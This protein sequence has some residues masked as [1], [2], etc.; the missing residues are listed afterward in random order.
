MATVTVNVTGGIPTP[1][2]VQLQAG[3]ILVFNNNDTNPYLIQLWTENQVCIEIGILLAASQSNV[4]LMTDPNNP[5][6]TIYYNLLVPGQRTNPA[7]GGHGIIV[8][9]GVPMKA[10]EAA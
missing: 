9:S 7:R 3:D 10:G 8:G 6:A 5:D 2:P 4:R 1:D